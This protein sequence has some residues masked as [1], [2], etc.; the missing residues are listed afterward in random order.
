MGAARSSLCAPKTTWRRPPS[1][2]SKLLSRADRRKKNSFTTAASPR[3]FLMCASK[4]SL[5]HKC[6]S[7]NCLPTCSRLRLLIYAFCRFPLHA[8]EVHKKTGT[9]A[10]LH[11]SAQPTDPAKACS[12]PCR[13]SLAPLIKTTVTPGHHPADA[14]LTVGKPARGTVYLNA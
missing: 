3:L 7:M 4:E 1:T 11:L 5:R 14:R 9:E 8:G 6:R 12:G 13:A 2:S 10:A